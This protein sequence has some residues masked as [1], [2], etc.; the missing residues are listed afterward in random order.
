MS[1]NSGGTDR[2]VRRVLA[3]AAGALLVTDLIVATATSATVASHKKK[4]HPTIGGTAIGMV[5]GVA[6][7]VAGWGSG[8]GSNPSPNPSQ[9]AKPKRGGQRSG[10]GVSAPPSSDGSNYRA[11]RNAAHPL[12]RADWQYVPAYTYVAWLK[13]HSAPGY[14]TRHSSTRKMSVP[15]AWYGRTTAMPITDTSATRVKVRLARRP[16]ESQIWV[17]RRAVTIGMTRY[18]LVLDLSKRR[19]YVFKS[20]RQIASY[21]VGVGLPQTPTPTGN[22]FIAFH[23]PPNGP[24]YG[25]V[26]LETSA[27]SKVFRTF[28]GGNDAI[29]AIHGPITSAS[30]AAIGK[31]GTRISNGCIRMHDGQLVK[32]AQV[33]D[34]TPLA[35]VS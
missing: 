24:G 8:G 18:A 22:Y 7:G 20:G 23:A 30:D 16:D 13:N 19:M 6:G 10:S 35:I 21:P 32:V 12:P 15:K 2:R 33:P 14:A 1:S 29:I 11:S 34:G 27:H 31:N 28:E 26:M 17:R 3:I 25:A 5:G 9:P 4:P